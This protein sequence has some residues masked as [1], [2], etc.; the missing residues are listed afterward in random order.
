[1]AAAATAGLRSSD[2]KHTLAQIAVVPLD[3]Y[4]AANRGSWGGACGPQPSGNPKFARFI[5]QERV[6][7]DV[8]VD[9]AQG[10]PSSSH[11]GMH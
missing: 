2:S 7:A 10:R 11:D 5:C 6:Q 3:L 9:P 1:L 8:P 4:Q